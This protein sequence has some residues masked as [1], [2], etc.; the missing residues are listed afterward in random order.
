MIKFTQNI[1]SAGVL[2]LFMTGPVAL[3][4]KSETASGVEPADVAAP[5]ADEALSPESE[6]ALAKLKKYMDGTK[7]LTA[8][9]TSIL[10]D[11]SGRKSDTSNGT[12]AFKVPGKFRWQYENPDPSVLLADGV[13]LWHFDEVLEQVIVSSLDD[14]RGANPSL[15][16]GGDSD[17]ITEGFKVVGSH[18]TEGDQW[19]VLETRD[20]NS[21][22]VTVRIKFKED[23]IELMEL[24][25]RVDQTS[26]ILFSDVTLNADIDDALFTFEVPEGASLNGQPTQR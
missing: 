6:E 2:A 13:D 1:L 3:A 16:L 22:F 20:R 23:T 7:S 25:D 24:V 4:Q 14:Y 12:V 11:D 15:L 10:L 26:R 21:D 9:F 8:E 18:K 5:L 19:I 17:K